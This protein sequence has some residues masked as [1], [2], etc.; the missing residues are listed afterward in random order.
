MQVIEGPLHKLM[1]EATEPVNYTLAVGA[2]GA[3]DDQDHVVLN[4]LIGTGI[5]IRFLDRISCSFCHARTPKSYSGGYCYPCFKRLARCDLCMVSPDRCHYHDGTCR[6]P[7]WGDSFCMQEHIVYLA[8]SSG[9]KVGITRGGGQIGRWLD[10]GACQAMPIMTA[11]TRRGAGIAEVGLAQHLSDRT[12]W[13]RLVSGDAAPVDLV[14]LREELK[15]KVG[16]LPEGVSWVDEQPSSFEY[17]VT[18]YGQR[19]KRLRLD[20]QSVVSGNLIGIKGQFLLFEHGVFNV[21]QHTSYH[22]R[23]T[24][25]GEPLATDVGGSDQMELFS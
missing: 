2:A 23:A 22:V 14:A 16:E 20:K 3:S 6:E 4:P 5:E 7:E 10:Q 25:F 17:P 24:A 19:A 11:S 9:P 13:R 15:G 1:V 8:N 12:D 18:G 21:R